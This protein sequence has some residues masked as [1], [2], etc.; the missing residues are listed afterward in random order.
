M[1]TFSINT[2]SELLKM[3][4][5]W[6]FLEWTEVGATNVNRKFNL[7]LNL[8]QNHHLNYVQLY[9]LTTTLWK[10]FDIDFRNSNK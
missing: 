7:Q 1:C 6:G 8:I 2:H 4:I 3:G 10:A 9:K 5:M